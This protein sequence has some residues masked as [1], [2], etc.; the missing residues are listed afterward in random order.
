MSD[1]SHLGLKVG[2]FEIFNRVEHGNSSVVESG[3]AVKLRISKEVDKG[4]LLDELVFGIDSVIF[5]LLLSVSEV[6]SLDFFDG[7]GPLVTELSV[8]V[9]G[10]DVVE[11]REFRSKEVSEVSDLNISE[12]VCEEEL[13]V[14]DHTS[15]PIVMLPSAHS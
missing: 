8:L 1:V 9:G 13:V 12:V 7:I 5:E 3:L 2:I 10:I 4:S 14:P 6:L 15:H 11:H